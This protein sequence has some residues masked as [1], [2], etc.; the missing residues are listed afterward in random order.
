MKLTFISSTALLFATANAWSLEA[1]CPNNLAHPLKWSGS[2]NRGCTKFG[3]SVTSC[4]TGDTFYWNNALLSDCVFR[5][6]SG[7]PCRADQEI[8]YSNDDWNKKLTRNAPYF[9]VTGC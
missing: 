1:Y 3:S 7:S 5:L 2:G 4:K 6:Y 9:G 8:G